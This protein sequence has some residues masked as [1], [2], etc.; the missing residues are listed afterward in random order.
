M[1]IGLIIK[2]KVIVYLLENKQKTIQ[3]MLIFINIINNLLHAF[4]FGNN[5]IWLTL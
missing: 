5:S 2:T 1:M 3:C 4:T